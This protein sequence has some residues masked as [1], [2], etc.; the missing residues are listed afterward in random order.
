MEIRFL[1]KQNREYI[2]KEIIKEIIYKNFLE[3]KDSSLQIK[4]DY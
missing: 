4:K 1:E 3:F 2:E